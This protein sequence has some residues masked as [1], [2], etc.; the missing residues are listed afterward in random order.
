MEWLAPSIVLLG[1]AVMLGIVSQVHARLMR[2]EHKLNKLLRH[3]NLEAASPLSER[4][5]TLADD[6]AKKIEAI[7]VYREE[8][9][10][11]LAEAKAAVE[12]YINSR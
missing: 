5:K 12:E 1:I 8:T 9:G 3:F 2:V 10:V 7:K 4:V 6:P 11:G